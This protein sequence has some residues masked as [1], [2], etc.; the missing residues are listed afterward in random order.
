[1]TDT[2]PS[3]SDAVAAARRYFEASVERPERALA[4]L[5]RV[6]DLLSTD[7]ASV[8]SERQLARRVAASATLANLASHDPTR[9]A[10][11]TPTLTAELRTEFDRPR[12]VSDRDRSARSTAVRERL[13]SCLARLG[14]ADPRTL[15]DLS[16][17]VVVA[18]A[19]SSDLNDSTVRTATRALVAVA[20]THPECLAPAVDSLATLLDHPDDAVAALCAGVLGRLA[21]T[22][23]EAVAGSADAFGALLERDQ[24]AQHNAVEALATVARRRPDAVAP[25]AEQLRGLLA[26]DSVPIQ[27]NATGVLGVLAAERPAVVRPAVDDLRA[28]R[29][30]DDDAVRRVAASTLVRLR[31]ADHG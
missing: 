5:P 12:P 2:E 17:C 26:H 14:L 3:D 23:P 19:L 31:R 13:V 6:L 7:D 15:V 11:A 20:E 10:D 4:D 25:L 8:A 1:M 16:D 21:E 18:D 9:L 28:L 29:D 24:T 30:H 27:H 22:R